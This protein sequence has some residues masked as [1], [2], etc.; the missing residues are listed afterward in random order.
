MISG[1]FNSWRRWT[2]TC[3]KKERLLVFGGIRTRSRCGREVDVGGD[4]EERAPTVNGERRRDAAAN[5]YIQRVPEP[6][7][8]SKAVLA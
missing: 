3:E 2:T 4:E 8:L 6:P 5:A 1:A 7:K